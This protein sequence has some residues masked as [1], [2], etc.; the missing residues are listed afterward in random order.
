M[1]RLLAHAWA[2]LASVLVTFAIVAGIAALGDP[3]HADPRITA[4]IR[5][6]TPS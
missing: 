4:A 6:A 5:S 1:N 2:A 3:G